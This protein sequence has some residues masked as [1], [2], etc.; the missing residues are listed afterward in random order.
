MTDLNII[1]DDFRLLDRGQPGFEGKKSSITRDLVNL[2]FAKLKNLDISHYGALVS[3][4]RRLGALPY[5][6]AEYS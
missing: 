6:P 3:E 2:E 4:A 5:L 1:F